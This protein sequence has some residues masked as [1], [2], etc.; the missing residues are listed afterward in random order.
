LKATVLAYISQNVSETKKNIFPVKS[1]Q[2]PKVPK[3]K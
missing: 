2:C 1:V 3:H